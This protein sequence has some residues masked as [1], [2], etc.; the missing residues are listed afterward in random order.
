VHAAEV[1]AA[2]KTEQ[3]QDAAAALVVVVHTQAEQ[4]VLVHL[5]K[6]RMVV[7]A[8]LQAAM[9]AAAAVH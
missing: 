2:H 7:Q 4:V 8:R 1:A 5:A 6:A 9:A 3:P